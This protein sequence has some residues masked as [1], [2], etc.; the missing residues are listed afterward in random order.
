MMVKKPK[1]EIVKERAIKH[2]LL[3]IKRNATVRSVA[4][5]TGASKTTVHLDLLRLEK[6]H[7]ELYKKVR[8]KLDYNMAVRHIRGGISNKENWERKNK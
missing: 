7:S 1:S 4:K 2:G 3:F 8:E 5:L 6:I